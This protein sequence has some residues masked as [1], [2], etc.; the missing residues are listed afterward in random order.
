LVFNS[1]AQVQSLEIPT[2]RRFRRRLHRRKQL[3]ADYRSPCGSLSCH[4]GLVT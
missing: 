3:F 4:T 1:L 2:H